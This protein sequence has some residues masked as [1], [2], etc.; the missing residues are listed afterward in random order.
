[1]GIYLRKEYLL[2]LFRNLLHEGLVSLPQFVNLVNHLFISVWNNKILISYFEVIIQHYFFFFFFFLI[3]IQLCPM[4]ALLVG[5]DVF[6]FCFVFFIVF[7]VVVVFSIGLI[8][9]HYLICILYIS[10]PSPRIRL[11][12]KKPWF[13]LLENGIINQDLD[14]SSSPYYWGIISFAPLHLS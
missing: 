11:F 12:S 8:F 5:S 1:M 3:L 14:T 9:W 10:G 6:L 4:G 7:V 13:L 2:K